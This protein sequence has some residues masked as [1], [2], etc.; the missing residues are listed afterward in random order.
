MNEP[1]NPAGS[2]LPPPP[3]NLWLHGLVML[4]LILLVNLAQ[5]VL[6]ICA[7][8]QFLWML[9]AD[10]RNVHVARFGGGLARWLETTARF[11]S[12]NADARPF[13]WTNWDDDSA[14]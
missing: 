12:G 10:E 9:I 8:V 14:P 13:P 4:A 3:D 11:V 2:T 7:I 5:T 6:G 1:Q